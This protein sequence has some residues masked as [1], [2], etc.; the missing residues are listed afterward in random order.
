MSFITGIIGQWIIRRVL[1]LGGL[2]AAAL[3]AWNNLPPSVQETIIGLLGNKW[4]EVT[5]GTAAG[6]A[7]AGWGYVW[8]FISTI[9]PHVTI[10]GVQTPVKALPADKQTV[11][12]ESARTAQT[13]RRT[14]MDIIQGK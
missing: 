13:K 4:Q 11:I 2:A 10:D 5:L 3:T 14:L 6:L 9:K 12:E 1:E 8:S 7:V